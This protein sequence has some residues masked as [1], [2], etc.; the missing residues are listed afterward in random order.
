MAG[1][2]LLKMNGHPI[3]N[4]RDANRFI[5]ASPVNQPYPVVVLRGGKQVTLTVKLTDASKETVSVNMNP[6]VVEAITDK[7]L[8]IQGEALSDALRTKFKL[9]PETTGVV[10]TVVDPN[11]LASLLGFA[12]GDVVIRMQDTMIHSVDDMRKVAGEARA[13]KR[14]FVAVLKANTQGLH[15]VGVP[16]SQ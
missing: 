11:G 6:P 14:Q 8:G 13:Q 4:L 16:I 3:R 12:V 15:W 2:I 10:L 9:K 1:D 5:A 7:Q